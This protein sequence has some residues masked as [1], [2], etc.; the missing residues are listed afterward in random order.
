MSC[1]DCQVGSFKVN[2][3]ANTGTPVTHPD[4]TPIGT[5][6]TG[7]TPGAPTWKIANGDGTQSVFGLMAWD[8]LVS[9]GWCVDEGGVCYQIQGCSAGLTLKF[10]LMIP[11]GQAPNVTVTTPGGVTIPSHGAP[12]KTGGNARYDTYRIDFNIDMAADCGTSVVLQLDNTWT[13]TIGGVGATFHNPGGN[14]K[15]TLECNSCEGAGGGS[16][17]GGGGEED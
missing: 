10:M 9:G 14:L 8:A 7:Q 5:S 15:F 1:E 13:I 2:D 6:H 11:K 12:R 3:V 16:D 17:P 4:G